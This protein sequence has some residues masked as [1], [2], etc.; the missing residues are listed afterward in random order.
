MDWDVK[1][2]TTYF[3]TLLQH[4]YGGIAENCETAFIAVS[5]QVK[6]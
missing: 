2:S 5:Y 1:A 3:K 4:L 6:N